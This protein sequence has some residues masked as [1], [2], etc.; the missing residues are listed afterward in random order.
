M[1]DKA[2]IYLD[3]LDVLAEDY[4][5]SGALQLFRSLLHLI[6][7]SK[8]RSPNLQSGTWKIS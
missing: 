2:S 8:G 4:S 3:A 7:E 5:T 1:G 6:K